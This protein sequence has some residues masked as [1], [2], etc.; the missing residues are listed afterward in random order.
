MFSEINLRNHSSLHKLFYSPQKDDVAVEAWAPF[1]EGKDC[2]FT[3]PV[4]AES[5]KKYGK[6]NGQIILRWL[7]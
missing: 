1:A 2:I 7:I 3:N 4:L 5:G 6:S